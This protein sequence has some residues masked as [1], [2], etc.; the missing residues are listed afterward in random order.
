MKNMIFFCLGLSCFSATA[1][2][3]AGTVFKIR[4][5][6]TGKYLRAVNPATGDGSA[7]CQYTLNN[8]DDHFLWTGQYVS[9]GVYKVRN[10]KTGKYMTVQ[11]AGRTNGSAIIQTTDIGQQGIKWKLDTSS[12]GMRLKNTNSNLFAAIEGG[13]PADGTRSIQWS[14]DG[15]RDVIWTFEVVSGRRAPVIVSKNQWQIALNLILATMRLRINN[16]TPAAFQFNSDNTYKFQKP[17][18]SKL[19]I[20]IAPNIIE[21]SFDLLPSRNNPATIYFSDINKRTAVVIPEGR[22]LKISLGFEEGGSEVLGNCIDN[23]ICGSGMWWINLQNMKVDLYLEPAIESGRLTY[24]NAK[25][26]VT[27]IAKSE[28]MN[29]VV[30]NLNNNTLFSKAS[31]VFTDILNRADIKAAFTDGLNSNLGRL[32]VALP[33]PLTSVSLLANGDLLFN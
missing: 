27:G 2:L 10:V 16:Y 13:G 22:Y 26:R 3:T 1:Q 28:G 21:R 20:G 11:N 29:I 9:P 15:Q 12:R 23:I 24:R 5:A 19:T 4:N 33:N 18:D 7:V 6:G 8:A 30:E 32:P 17:N 25:A 31:D 14:D